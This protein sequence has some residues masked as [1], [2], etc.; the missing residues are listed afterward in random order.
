MCLTADLE[1]EAPTLTVVRS[2][3]TSAGILLAQLQADD[4]K[5][6]AWQPARRPESKFRKEPEAP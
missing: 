6:H 1:V 4:D 5:L 3:M 2:A